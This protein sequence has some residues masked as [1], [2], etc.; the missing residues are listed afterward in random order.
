MLFQLHSFSD[1]WPLVLLIYDWNTPA[2]IAN[3][4]VLVF[5]PLVCDSLL[6][7]WWCQ[8]GLPPRVGED[9][10]WLSRS[11]ATSRDL[12]YLSSYIWLERIM[13]AAVDFVY[14]YDWKD[15]HPASGPRGVSLWQWGSSFACSPHIRAERK[16]KETAL[17]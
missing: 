11:A 8:C 9:P 15:R 3:S 12:W 1:L 17:G 16:A 13:A 6:W 5:D 14:D 7:R 10:R 4:L 2:A